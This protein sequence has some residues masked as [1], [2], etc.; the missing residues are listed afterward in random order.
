M[1]KRR[2]I[3]A[4][5]VA[6]L[7][8][9]GVAVWADQPS[10]TDLQKQVEALQ[11]KV[12]Q[13]ESSRAYNQ[14][15]VNATVDSIVRDADTRS[16]LLAD[17]GGI[18]AGW[19]N[20]FVLS[21]QD[22]N[23][24]M[25]P[26]VQFQFRSVTNYNDKAGGDNWDNGFES[27]RMKFSLEGNAISKALT[28]NF[29]WATDR[30]GGSLV[31]EE[32]YIKYK[33]ADTFAVQV[34]QYKETILLE[35]QTSSKRQMA[36]E[37]SI[38]A[39]VLLSGDA[40]SQGVQLIYDD[41]KSLQASLGFTDGYNS[42]NTNFRDPP[43]NGF[44]WGMHARVQY[45]VFGDPKEGWANYADFTAQGKD[46]L[47]IGAGGDWSQNGDI[48]IFRHGVDIQYETGGKLGLM[49]AYVGNWT[50]NN[51][52]DDTY[53]WGLVVQ[54][55]YMIDKNMEIFARGAYLSLDSSGGSDDT[56]CEI[57]VG[58]NYYILKHNAKI[59]VDLGWLPS[60]APSDITS[61]GILSNDGDNE[62][63]FRAQF[64]LLL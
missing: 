50:R 22:G 52:G 61:A 7:S 56:F 62:F 45:M 27:R 20:G 6:A 58:L 49:A 53:D 23:W 47:V 5:M 15:D 12:A 9:G 17:S 3:P 40:Y 34:G 21:S 30:V 64:Q 42:R 25:K 4:L 11:A 26:G 38:V 41:Q 19:D 14:S 51:A 63:Y 28:Y 35:T 1:T 54:A 44:D 32:A 2:T 48:D 8:L 37:R 59:T 36:V 24:S 10:Q 55:A 29:V 31:N 60:G 16:K 46:L 13:L 43:T 18:L 33:F 57:T 39:E